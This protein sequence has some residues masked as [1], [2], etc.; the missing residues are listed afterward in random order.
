MCKTATFHGSR[1]LRESMGDSL[2]I[3]AG[4]MNRPR[5]Y[6]EEMELRKRDRSKRRRNRNG[7]RNGEEVND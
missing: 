6:G 2:N 7:D 4:S 5:D 3:S 1:S